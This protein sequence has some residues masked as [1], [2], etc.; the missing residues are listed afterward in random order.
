MAINILITAVAILVFY[1]FPTIY[2]I[3]LAYDKSETDAG[4]RNDNIVVALVPIINFVGAIIV[5]FDCNKENKFFKL[6]Y[7]IAV[8]HKLILYLPVVLLLLIFVV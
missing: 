6:F 1:I 8:K 3:I 5:N 2:L 4:N 7:N